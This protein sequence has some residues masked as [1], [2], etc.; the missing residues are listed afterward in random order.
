MQLLRDI[1]KAEIE[2]TLDELPD[3]AYTHVNLLDPQAIHTIIQS[4]YLYPPIL[5]NREA[6]SS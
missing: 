4:I 3:Y 6:P 5:P 1:F 2:N